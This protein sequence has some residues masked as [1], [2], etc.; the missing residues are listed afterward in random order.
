VD[1]FGNHIGLDGHKET[2]AVAEAGGGE[3]RCVGEI[4]NTPEALTKLQSD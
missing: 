1:E 2:I 3:A 4:A